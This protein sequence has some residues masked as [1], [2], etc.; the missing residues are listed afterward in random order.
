RTL[1]LFTVDRAGGSL[2]LSVGEVAD[3]LIHDYGVYNALN[4]DGGGSATLAMEHPITHQRSIVNVSSDNPNGRAVASSLA[5]FAAA[6]TIA[7]LT[8]ADLTPA[9]PATHW[10]NSTIT[11]TLEATDNPG[12]AVRD[13]HYAFTGAHAEPP[14]VVNGDVLTRSIAEEGSTTV[15][16]F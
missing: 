9:P 4:L 10:N 11:L 16:F 2:G 1:F 13:L 15:T 5:V 12:G 3:I 6:D 7:P 14:A 8:V